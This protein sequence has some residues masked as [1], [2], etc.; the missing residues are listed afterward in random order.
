MSTKEEQG[1]GIK[2]QAAAILAGIIFIVQ[3]FVFALNFNFQGNSMVTLIGWLLF[4]PSF[5]LIIL[6]RSSLKSNY[7]ACADGSTYLVQNDI[8]GQVRHP[9][10][11]GWCLLVIALAITSQF[12]FST[13]L[14]ILQ[15]PLIVFDIICEEELNKQKFGPD[16]D[17]YQERVPMLN[18]LVGIA[19]TRSRKTHVELQNN[20]SIS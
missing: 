8:Y 18:I 14:M 5:L 7:E 10:S 1:I 12:W 15:I 17:R 9:F 4:I 20:E 13:Y 2:D 11:L 16:Y 3:F 6:S 19:R